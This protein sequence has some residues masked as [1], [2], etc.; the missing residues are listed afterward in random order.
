MDLEFSA[1]SIDSFPAPDPSALPAGPI[2]PCDEILRILGRSPNPSSDRR[3]LKPGD[4]VPRFAAAPTITAR[5]KQSFSLLSA[6][7]SLCLP[8]I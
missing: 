4:A 1:D 7:K 2:T 5:K 6:L 3:S 8:Q